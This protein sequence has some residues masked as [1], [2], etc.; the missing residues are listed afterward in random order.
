[1]EAYKRQQPGDRRLQARNP[2]QSKPVRAADE[3]VQKYSG[4]LRGVSTQ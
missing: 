3:Y 4:Q 2:L 1:M